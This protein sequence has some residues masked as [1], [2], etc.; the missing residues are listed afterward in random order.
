[1]GVQLSTIQTY[2]SLSEVLAH[3]AEAH[4]ADAVA[5]AHY[6]GRLPFGVVAVDASGRAIE[7]QVVARGAGVEAF[8]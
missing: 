3:A 1:M 8:A 4:A 6:F 5:G 2:A 7:A